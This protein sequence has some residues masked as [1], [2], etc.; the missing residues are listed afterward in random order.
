MLKLDIPNE[1]N[2]LNFSQQPVSIAVGVGSGG[3]I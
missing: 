1:L 3:P 2:D